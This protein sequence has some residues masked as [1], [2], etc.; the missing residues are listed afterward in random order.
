MSR[1]APGT[2]FPRASGGES[3][4]HL[5][6]H[7]G[8]QPEE[9]IDLPLDLRQAEFHPAGE[10]K[11]SQA[12]LEAWRD[13]LTRWA[14][15]RQF[16]ASLNAERRSAWDVA[17]GQR[18]LEDV[19]GLPEAQHPD[20]WCWIATHLLP[21]FV[22]HR[23]GW[24]DAKHGIVP[25]RNSAWARFG[26]DL[27]NGLRI[28]M[29]R[30][31]TYRPD[32]ASSASEQEFQSIQN[33]PAFGLDRRVARI[34]MRTLLDCLDD[35]DS[36]Y[37]KHGGTRALDNDDVCIE[38][39]LINSLRPLCFASDEEICEIVLDAVDRLPSYRKPENTARAS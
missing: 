19:E 21:H 36:N 18:L 14:Y 10:V 27:R 7:H 39:R 3:W 38:L 33:R 24:P 30:I 13:D 25:E 20:V 26:R 8:K 1:F 16:P 34:V 11:V 6:E 23:W 15:E 12:E 28:T 17:L 32:V 31:Q 29:H 35:P 22:V 2:H 37:G 9:L 5:L 4:R